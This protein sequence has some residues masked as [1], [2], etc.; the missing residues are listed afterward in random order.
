MRKNQQLV[1][2]LPESSEELPIRIVRGSRNDYLKTAVDEI[3]MWKRC[4][5]IR[6]PL[7]VDEVEALGTVVAEAGVAGYQ[8]QVL[9]DGVGDDDVV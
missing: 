1:I 3:H 7:I 9:G 6:L 2:V 5:Q 4:L 8:R